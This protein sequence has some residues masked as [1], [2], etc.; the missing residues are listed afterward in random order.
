MLES[1][2]LT[3]RLV[4][5]KSSPNFPLLSKPRPALR[6]AKSMLDVS[7]IQER[8]I[9][10]IKCILERKIGEEV[11]KISYPP[12]IK[13]GPLIAILDF[14]KNDTDDYVRK[15]VAKACGNIGDNDLTRTIIK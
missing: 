12:K 11:I 4:R 8:N 15:A 1:A 10:K 6:R 14:L 13:D 5:S 9:S 2:G 7:D 3:Q